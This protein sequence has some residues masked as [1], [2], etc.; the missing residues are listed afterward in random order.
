MT[1]QQILDE[2]RRTAKQN[3]GVALGHK[4]FEQQ[5]GN[6]HADWWGKHWGRWG[7]AVTEAGLSPN[8]LL[9]AFSDGIL[10]EKLIAFIRELGR[11]PGNGNLRL[12]KRKDQA[13]PNDKVFDAHFGSRAHLRAS[14][15]DWCSS[16][17]GHDDVSAL[18]GPV[19]SDGDAESRTEVKPSTEVVGFVYLMKHRKYHKIGKTNAMGRREY[20]LAIQLPEKLRTV[21]VIRTDDPDGIEEY[22]HK[23]FASKRGNGE[24][25]ELEPADVQAFKR[26]KF[27]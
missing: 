22:W 10:L 27:M 1:R 17:P 9:D 13:F 11:F 18:C 4:R 25:F 15:I 24:W 3:G 14:V 23:R 6:R 8:T 20:E 19:N 7:D 5:T 2:I 16:H 21:H 26:R 12:K